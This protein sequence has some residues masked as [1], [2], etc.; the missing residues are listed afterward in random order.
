MSAAAILDAASLADARAALARC[1]G[2]ARWVEGMLARR[3]FH[4]DDALH[5]AAD[6]VWATMTRADILEAF[7]HHPAIGSDIAALRAKFASTAGWSEGEQSAIAQADEA[8]LLR[9]RDAN[10]EYHRRF[11]FIFI[12]CATGKTAQQMLALLEAR[13]SN[14]VATEL[15]VAADE[16]ARITRLRLY[17]LA[18]GA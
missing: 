6:T 17:K 13:L 10:V 3:P 11:G 16:Q 18:A 15:R 4:G 7:S 9:L 8:T 5:A 14:D 12:V 2:A 1:C